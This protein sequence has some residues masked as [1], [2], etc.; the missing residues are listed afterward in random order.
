[1]KKPVWQACRPSHHR[2]PPGTTALQ[3]QIHGWQ[4]A[5]PARK[6]RSCKSAR[7]NRAFFY[8]K[9]LHGGL[10]KASG[11]P[12][13]RS[14]RTIEVLP[15]RMTPSSC[16]FLIMRRTNEIVFSYVKVYKG[17]GVQL[18]ASPT[19]SHHD[20]YRLDAFKGQCNVLHLSSSR[21]FSFLILL[22]DYARGPWWA[23]PLRPSFHVCPALVE[24]Y[25]LSG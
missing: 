19:K 18:P 9:E 15:R 23:V 6:P 12:L 25:F 8:R 24:Q 14:H 21:L 1:M 3:H 7:R 11:L 13:L 5:R 20:R 16:R 22:L 2:R 17:K 4:G 10:R